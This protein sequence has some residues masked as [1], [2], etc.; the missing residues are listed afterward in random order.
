M[1][2]VVDINDICLVAEGGDS[3][4]FS[5]GYVLLQRGQDPVVGEHAL[6]QS[7][8]L[9]AAT[10]NRFWRDLSLNPVGISHP[11][12]RH[13]ADLAW[14]Q[15]KQINSEV[16]L[17]QAL[18]LCPSHYGEQQLSLLSGILKAQGISSSALIKRALAA[19]VL[20]EKATCYLEF[21]LHQCLLTVI[22]QK[23]EERIAEETHALPGEGYIGA[24]DSMLKA[25]QQR[26]IKETR[27]DP[28]H[29]ANT[30]Q[31]LVDSLPDTLQSLHINNATVATVQAGNEEYR[32]EI[33]R[34][35]LEQALKHLWQA[36]DSAITTGAKVLVDQSV[37][38][39]PGFDKLSIESVI[40]SPKALSQ[41]A[42]A[43][44]LPKST[45]PQ[46]PIYLTRAM[47]GGS[48]DAAIQSE[49]VSVEVRSEAEQA[50]IPSP[51]L[52]ITPTPDTANQ[53]A[54]THLLCQGR[55]LGGTTIWL[56][57]SDHGSLIASASKPGQILATCKT[58]QAGLEIEAAGDIYING[59]KLVGSRKLQLADH[60]SSSEFP[61]GVTAIQVVGDVN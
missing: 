31:Q 39:L 13:Q 19:A 18:F 16:P 59:E 3:T 7:R 55:A 26:F 49:S 32:A 12:V 10:A 36:I 20:D 46:A 8:L 34:D 5:P 42:R 48:S 17:D 51:T 33:R 29:H 28:L 37:S 58:T 24:I 2:T 35:E 23:G 52:D 4:I 22:Q 25:I 54:A 43:L 53:S 60:L 15:L 45:D 6:R 40:V 47:T 41:S 57:V 38:Q 30:E 14:H 27:F 56:C 1:T 11:Q 21:Q 9:P 50:E 61:G 44:P